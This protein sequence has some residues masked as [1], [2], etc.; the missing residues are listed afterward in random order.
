[1][2]PTVLCLKAKAKKLKPNKIGLVITSHYK[3]GP[4]SAL[5]SSRPNAILLSPKNPKKVQPTD[6]D[7]NL[8]TDEG[9]EA[10][11]SSIQRSAQKMTITKIKS[12]N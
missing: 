8:I 9:E 1:V 3:K 10:Q 5:N 2:S 7:E 11:A 6:S 4:N 12:V